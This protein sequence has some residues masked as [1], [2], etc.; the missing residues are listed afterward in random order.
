MQCIQLQYF[1]NLHPSK[2][3]QS[4]HFFQDK[5]EKLTILE[6]GCGVGNFLFPL[7]SDD[8]NIFFYACD[9]SPRAIAFV[10]VSKYVPVVWTN[11]TMQ[12]VPNTIHKRFGDEN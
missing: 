1:H 10:K 12:L 5:T 3:T 2:S 4:Y 11:N 9:F 8:M 7:I 6:V